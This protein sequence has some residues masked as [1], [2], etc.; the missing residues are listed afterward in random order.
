M[1]NLFQHLTN[2]AINRDN[3]NFVCDDS[4]EEEGHKRSLRSVL[5]TVEGMGFNVNDLM[6]KITDLIIKT[7]VSAQPS[8]AHSIRSCQPE[9]VENQMVYEIL[10]FDILLDQKCKPWLLE[11]NHSPSF[12][13]ETGLDF[14]VKK[15]LVEDTIHLLSLNIKRKQAYKKIIEERYKQRVFTG[16]REKLGVEEKEQMR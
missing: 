1:K 12:K 7:L 3:E 5:A 13:T 9:D 11:V 14:K 10:G 6:N 2:Y 8:L 15:A 4:Y 16:K